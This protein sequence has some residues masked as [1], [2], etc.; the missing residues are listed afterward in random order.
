MNMDFGE[1]LMEKGDT[2]SYNEPKECI[3]VLVTGKV[4][5]RWADKEET[6]ERKSCFH[7]DPILLHVPQNT[8][9]ELM[10]QSDKAEVSIQRTANPKHFEPKLMKG[11]DLLCGSELRGA[12]L[13]NEASTYR[14]YLPGS[15]QLPGDKL[16]YRRG[17]ELPRK[18]S[19]FPPIPTWSL[20]STFISSCPKMA[21]AMPRWE[22]PS[23]K[24]TTMT[25]PA[26]PTA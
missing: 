7:E 12:G 16:L 18:W 6:V 3:Y 22:T 25:P 19:S 9:V 20:R 5:F 14:A 11:E 1:L 17:G 4:T 24:F 10:C 2:V 13:M 15:L 23:I 26:W 8:A 21:T